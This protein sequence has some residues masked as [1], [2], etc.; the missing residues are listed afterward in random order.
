MGYFEYSELAT[1]PQTTLVQQFLTSGNRVLM[2]AAW[3]RT[4]RVG[5]PTSKRGVWLRLPH[6]PVVEPWQAPTTWGEL[7]GACARVGINLLPLLQQA[8]H[9]VRNDKQNLGLLGFPLPK[10]TGQEPVQM[11]WQGFVFPRLTSKGEHRNGFR[12]LAKN[13]WWLDRQRALSPT[14][15][16]EWLKSAN[17]S[18][19]EISARGRLTQDV[20]AASIAVIGV[21][22]LGSAVA[23][24]LARA[25]V[26]DLLLI[27]GDTLE[28]GNLVRHTLTMS[29]LGKKKAEALSV[30]LVGVSPNI[31]VGFMA[32]EFP[33]QAEHDV[34]RL[35]RVAVIVDT[36]G[37]DEVVSALAAQQ[38]PEPKLVISASLSLGAKR[39]YIFS[40]HGKR[41]PAAEFHRHVDPLLE[42]D[43]EEWKSAG[44]PWEGVGCW[45][46]VFPAR[47]DDIWLM[48][49]AT[50]KE[51]EAV[52]STPP[53]GHQ[54]SIIEQVESKDG[55]GG[56]R[57][58]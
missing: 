33:L 40:S 14:S 32:R 52:V 6:L 19:E 24:L 48:A 30:R 39:A 12:P 54:F 8:S 22:A 36:T 37:S 46:P 23:E 27:D 34:E 45:H 31:E 53:A 26:A 28:V 43:A 7:E 25:G 58:L 29:D 10:T 51:I 41:F 55:F 56:L 35:G 42:R 1:I 17:W 11:H 3:S 21:G 18:A 5:R 44:L 47:L 20:R 15:S 13:Q 9:L 38:W 2:E 50:I 4:Y 57:R 49:S 16:I